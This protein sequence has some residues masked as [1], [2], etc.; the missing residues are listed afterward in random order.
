VGSSGQT[1]DTARKL[2][3]L[4]ALASNHPFSTSI[5]PPG[6]SSVSLAGGAESHAAVYNSTV[7]IGA[8]PI[9]VRGIYT[10]PINAIPKT[11]QSRRDRSAKRGSRAQSRSQSPTG[12]GSWIGSRAPN[13]ID[14]MT[15]VTQSRDLHV[16]V[17]REVQAAIASMRPAANGDAAL[18][19]DFTRILGTLQDK[20]QAM[21]IL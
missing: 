19:R 20:L 2:L 6:P 17:Q 5:S 8:L 14:A 18:G 16:R 11:R 15:G 3:E 7:Q 1:T 13:V 21:E 12:P 9:E 10:E 4:M